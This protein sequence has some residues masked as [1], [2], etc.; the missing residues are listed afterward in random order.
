MWA[1]IGL[2][3]LMLPAAH[4]LLG[5]SLLPC[6]SQTEHER[7]HA[8]RPL[9]TRLLVDISWLGYMAGALFCILH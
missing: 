6:Q 2:T 3:M 1:V 9:R 8:T 7:H 4:L 5:H